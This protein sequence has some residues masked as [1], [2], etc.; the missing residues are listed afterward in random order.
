VKPILNRSCLRLIVWPWQ[1]L[2]ESQ[3]HAATFSPLEIS[4]HWILLNFDNGTFPDTVLQA[5][6]FL[7]L[8]ADP[9]P[10]QPT[11]H[12]WSLS[13]PRG[14]SFDSSA[15]L[16]SHALWRMHSDFTSALNVHLAFEVPFMLLPI[17]A[18]ESSAVFVLPFLS[19]ALS[20]LFH[21]APVRESRL[22]NPSASAWTLSWSKRLVD[23]SVALLVLAF[24]AVPL[25]AIALCVRLTSPGPAFFTQYR[26]G[27]RGRHFRIYKFRTM[28]FGSEI[29]GPGLTRDGDC[30]I[31]GVGLWLRKLKLDEFPQF[32]NV[33][34]GDM[35]LVGLRPKLPQYLGIANMPYR[36][37]VTGAA[38]LAFRHEENIL[39]RVHP[40]Q[41]DDFYHQHILPLKA[42]ID[43]RYMCRATFWSDMRLV[44][45]TFIACLAP[46]PAIFRRAATRI[47]AFPPLP[48]KE[49]SAAKSFETA[50]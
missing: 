44:G 13:P 47:L 45:A 19:S 3:A 1:K 42:R 18:F 38:S 30:R 48:A 26:V 24:F 41:M 31:T 15:Y 4:F 32:Y 28:S 25:L 6:P 50:L 46:A 12:T 14:K 36:P 37:G 34:R 23:L 33:L 29:N 9:Q 16:L 40:S 39:S 5:L 21:S 11:M 8:N 22:E 7:S 43:A 10:M 20:P 49:S 35:S 2:R 27:R 17:R